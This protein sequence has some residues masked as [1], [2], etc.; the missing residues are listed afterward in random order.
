MAITG[1]IGSGKSVVSRILA[2]MGY[3]VYDCDSRAKWLMDTSDEIKDGLRRAIHS[4][5]VKDGVIDRSLV[6]AIVFA[7]AAKLE[8]LNTIVHGAVKE[9]IRRWISSHAHASALF[10]ETAILYQSGL[11]RMADQVWEVTAPEEL[12]IERVMKRNGLTAEE[13]AARIQSQEFMPDKTHPCVSELVNDGCRSLLL[14]I[15]SL[16]EALPQSQSHFQ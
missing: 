14:Q 8:A 13:V 15:N 3:D 11:D 1:G 2:A 6:S 9:D 16:L 12:R 10:I 5:S 7:D 4:E